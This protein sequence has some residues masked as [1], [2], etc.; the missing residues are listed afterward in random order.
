MYISRNIM[1]HKRNMKLFLVIVGFLSFIHLGK[2]QIDSN[3]LSIP[4]SSNTSQLYKILKT[5]GGELIGEIIKQDS[6]DV[7]FKTY[8]GREFYIPQYIIKSIVKLNPKIHNITFLSIFT[9]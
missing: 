8:D 1:S 5:D 3:F 7:F 9:Y 6:R 2:S 4:D